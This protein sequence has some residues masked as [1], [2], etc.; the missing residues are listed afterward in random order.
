MNKLSEADIFQINPQ[1]IRTY[2]ISEHLF[3]LILVVLHIKSKVI[4]ATSPRLTKQGFV[5]N[6]S[7]GKQSWGF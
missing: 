3:N 7:T 4:E 6:H 5:K 1:V 2:N